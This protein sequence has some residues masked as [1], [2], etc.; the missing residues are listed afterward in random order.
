MVYP[1]HWLI[2][3]LVVAI[4]TLGCIPVYGTPT[5]IPTD[6]KL[7]MHFDEIVNSTGNL[8][9]IGPLVFKPFEDRL[10]IQVFWGFIWVII[11]VGMF[12]VQEETTV[13][14]PYGMLVIGIILSY[15]VIPPEFVVIAHSLMVVALFGAGYL[16]ITKKVR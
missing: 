16:L 1:R 3:I 6:T 4:F 12:L 14:I 7:I 15:S 11:F 2:L 13:I 9:V 5:P 10:G 8:S